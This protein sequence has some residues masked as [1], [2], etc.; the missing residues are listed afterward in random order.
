MMMMIDMTTRL[1]G[2]ETVIEMQIVCYAQ[3]KL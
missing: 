3:S 2:T 1:I